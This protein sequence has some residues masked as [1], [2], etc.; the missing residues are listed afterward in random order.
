VNNIREN[1]S[2]KLANPRTRAYVHFFL[3]FIGA[4]GIL[5][6]SLN[7]EVLQGIQENQDKVLHYKAGRLIAVSCFLLVYFC[8]LARV[9]FVG[10]HRSSMTVFLLWLPTMLA[11]GLVIGIVVALAFA[12]IKETIDG[13]GAGSVEWLDITATLDGA[14]SL[15]GPIALIIAIT[16]V[17]IPLD[18]LMQLPKLLLSDVRTGLKT[19]DNYIKE[20]RSHENLK[21]HTDVLVVEDDIMC[22]TTV[23][24]FCRRNDLKC[25]HISTASEADTYLRDNIRN[26]RLVVLDN[27]L[28]VDESGNRMTGGE[29]LMMISE[30]FPVNKRPFLVVIISG[31]TEFLRDAASQAN[32]VLQKPWDPHALQDFLRE[33]KIINHRRT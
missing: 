3:L 29:W 21:K 20:S 18:M 30:E 1:I 25:H 33:N 16:P 5:L 32:L 26:I 7:W 6:T 4:A 11:A 17:L 15:T 24:N 12:V 23:M 9:L 19:L 14:A 28:R 10:E 22:A 8:I 2:R 31:H 27:F 13:G